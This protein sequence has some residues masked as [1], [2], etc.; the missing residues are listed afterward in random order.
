[1]KLKINVLAVML[2]VLQAFPAMSAP[3]ALR[4]LSTSSGVLI[5]APSLTMPV[6]LPAGLSAALPVVSPQAQALPAAGS[7]TLLTQRLAPAETGAQAAPAVQE[8]A[9]GTF[10]MGEKP[11]A[12]MT[13]VM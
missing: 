7:L 6:A 5:Q 12:A 10:Y 1:M 4:T 9:L 2:A 3:L 13:E 8:A 11:R